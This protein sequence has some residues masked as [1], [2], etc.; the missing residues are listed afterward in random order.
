MKVHSATLAGGDNNQ[1]RLFVTDNAVILLDGATA[2]EPVDI[3]AGHYAETLGAV[4]AEQLDQQ[5]G[6]P[7]ADA[8]AIA[9]Q[10]TTQKLDLAIGGSPSS[11]VSVLRNRPST[12]D[13]YVLGDTPIHYGTGHEH[14]VLSDERLSTVARSERERYRS[15]L[16]AGH[17]YGPEHRATLA[18]LQQ[19]QRRARNHP[20]GYWIAET[21]PAAAHHGLTATIRANS[22]TWAVLATDGA[23]DLIDHHGPAWPRISHF[24][25]DALGALLA[26]LHHWETVCDPN[27]L[28]LPR[29]KPHDDKTLCTTLL[30]D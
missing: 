12:V 15:Q 17:G 25:R 18:D 6:I 23:A 10:H 21:D 19:A 9:I 14:R 16:R 20:R 7:I 4:I 8:V 27:G 30:F 24:S 26:E 29:A 11:T 1:D 28:H 3:D 13:L 2:F 22:I 5:S